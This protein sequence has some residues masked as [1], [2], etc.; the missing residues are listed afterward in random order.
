MT[1]AEMEL[2][3]VYTSLKKPTE[4]IYTTTELKHD[5]KADHQGALRPVATV[6]KNPH[7]VKL[8]VFF[9]VLLVGIIIFLAAYNYKGYRI[10]GVA[11]DK[12]YKEEQLQNSTL[13]E[14]Y[15]KLEQNYAKLSARVTAL[16]KQCQVRN[17]SAQGRKDNVIYA[18][19]KLKNRPGQPVEETDSDTDAEEIRT[20]DSQY[21]N[22]MMIDWNLVEDVK[23][24]CGE[25]PVDVISHKYTAKEQKLQHNLSTA[26]NKSMRLQA[27]LNIMQL[28]LSDLQNQAS[29]LNWSCNELRFQNRELKQNQSELQNK[30]REMREKQT[31]LLFENAKLKSNQSEQ[32]KQYQE[33]KDN[34]S[35]LTKTQSVLLAKYQQLNDNHSKLTADFNE[36]CP[37]KDKDVTDLKEEGHIEELN[38]KY[39]AFHEQLDHF[40]K[41]LLSMSE[42]NDYLQGNLSEIQYQYKEMSKNLNEMTKINAILNRFCPG[43]NTLTQADKSYWIGLTDQVT[44]GQFIWVDGTPVAQH[45]GWDELWGIRTDGRREP[46]NWVDDSSVIGEDCVYICKIGGYQGWYDAACQQKYKRICEAPAALVLTS[47]VSE[48]QSGV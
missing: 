28:Q 43:S 33:L 44:E 31:A 25:T 9:C 3:G 39:A 17:T 6:N 34:Q 14:K 48:T 19:V 45:E 27:D 20:D 46:D 16:D 2:E 18:E 38:G 40:K 21:T 32:Q 7:L 42:E 37:I 13:Q 36:Y 30:T 41:E 1:T 24:P 22:Y 12:N 8:L 29:A 47:P 10:M 4:D 23:Q 35:E 15:T 5:K 26:E 11:F